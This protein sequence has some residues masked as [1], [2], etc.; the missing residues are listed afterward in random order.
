M[1]RSNMLGVQRQP[2]AP[3]ARVEGERRPGAFGK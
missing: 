1:I 2:A 3:G